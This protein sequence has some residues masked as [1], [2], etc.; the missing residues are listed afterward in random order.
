MGEL[1]TRYVKFGV[2]WLLLIGLV[3]LYNGYGC[4]RVLGPEMEPTI[5]KEQFRTLYAGKTKPAED[6]TYDDVVYYE[7]EIS[8]EPQAAFV[9]RVVGLPGDRIRI[10]KGEVY[11]NGTK[12]AQPYVGQAHMTN[13]DY[14]E[15][16]VPKESFFVLMDNRQHGKRWDSR[17]IGPVGRYAVAGKVKQ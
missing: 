14:E 13:E 2:A 5:K 10:A 3:I 12:V 1:I 9:A 7:Y 8:G 17:A 4:R 15:V 11:R 16:L 6:V